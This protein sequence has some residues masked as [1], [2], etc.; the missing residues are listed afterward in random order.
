MSRKIE[1]LQEAAALKAQEAEERVELALERMI[2]QN[3]K[4][5]FQSVAHSANVSTAYLYKYPEIKQRIVTLRDQQKNQSKPKQVPVASDNSKAVIIHNLREETKRLRGEI[6][7]LRRANEV[8]TGRLY[9]F[10]SSYDLAERL[11]KENESLLLQIKD[12]VQRLQEC[13]AKLPQKVTPI[14]QA[15]RANISDSVQ[16]QLA[17]VGIQLNPTLTKAIKLASDEAVLDA[18]EAYKE[19]LATGKVERPGA[20]LKKAIE[21]QWKPNDTV[22]AQSEQE[23]FNEWF[24]LAQKQGL[25]LASQKGKNG[26][27]VYTSNEQWIP[28]AEMLNQYPLATL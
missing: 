25:V 2:K 19:A 26:I 23:V 12:L 10:Q 21:E 4:I 11:K 16:N 22:Q 8:L 3:Q 5:N 7:E 1:A 6:S 18:I 28:L 13:E 20:W 14:T 27:E 15:K 9:H 24:P 17:A